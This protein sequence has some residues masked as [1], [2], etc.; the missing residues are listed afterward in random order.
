MSIYVAQNNAVL[1]KK[2]RSVAELYKGDKKIFGYKYSSG[3]IVK[4]DDINPIKHKMKV[5]L[6][7]DTVDDFSGIE[8]TQ[9]GKNL[10]FFPYQTMKQSGDTYNIV[11]NDDGT[12]LGNGS[13]SGSWSHYLGTGD[14]Y[15]PPFKVGTTYRVSGLDSKYGNILIRVTDTRD[16]SNKYFSSGNTSGFVWQTYYKYVSTYILFN[17]NVVLDNVLIKPQ[18]EIGNSA[19]EYEAPIN[20]KN[21]ITALSDNE[22]KVD[23]MDSKYPQMTLFTVADGVTVNCAYI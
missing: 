10:M 1:L 4:V 21:V 8:I 2:D 13:K 18:L 5:W 12:I 11:V 9:K 20:N 23:G 3:E 14:H 19:T 7:S 15:K 6:T 22:G 17:N 16:N